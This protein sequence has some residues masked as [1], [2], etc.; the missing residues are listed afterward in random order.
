[1]NSSHECD[2]GIGV[3]LETTTL[4]EFFREG[5]AKAQQNQKVSLQDTTQFYVVNLLAEFL[6]AEKL[7]K[8]TAGLNDAPLAFIYAR[9]VDAASPTERFQLL[10]T[11]GD[12]SLYV[13]GF[14][15]DS[16]K[17]KMIDIDYYIA[18]GKLAYSH[19]SAISRGAPGKVFSEIFQE[20]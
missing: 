4:M 1:R 18:M 9:A 20:L 19:V 10:K 2:G 14:F 17:R 8:A 16:F 7:R 6:A 5:F 12:R 11:V 13:S 3:G 15:P